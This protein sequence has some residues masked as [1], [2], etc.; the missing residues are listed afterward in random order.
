V[1]PR[2]CVLVVVCCLSAA[3]LGQLEVPPC[4]NR[5]G[6]VAKE[7]NDISVG[8][9]RVF[10]NR[11]L[12]LMLESLSST[13][14][15]QQT[16]FIDQ[17]ALSAALATIQGMRSADTNSSLTITAT[18]LPSQELQAVTKAGKVD[19]SG[20]IHCRTQLK[21]SRTPSDI[22]AVL[23]TTEATSRTQACGWCRCDNRSRF[24]RPRSASR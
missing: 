20:K 6:K 4:E 7:C 14:Q 5:A 2:V 13:L 22:A 24:P 3:A 23:G 9:P 17:K 21:P 11:T 12:T 1:R 15:T 18:P 8:E 16:Q 19:S 10:D